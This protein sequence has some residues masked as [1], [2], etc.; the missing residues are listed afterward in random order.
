MTT[1]SSIMYQAA[2]A[3]QNFVIEQNIAKRSFIQFLDVDFNQSDASSAVLQSLTTGLASGTPNKYVE[4]L[5]YG[6]NVSSST[7]PTGVN[8]FST[9]TTASVTLSG[10]NLSINLGANGITSLLAGG[11]GAS[12]PTKTYGDGWY[13]L[14][15]DPTGNP[16]DGQVFWEPF[17]RL[18]GDATG[19]GVV[20]GPY[21][22]AGT[23]AY[24]VYHAE[25]QSG[26]LLNADV[27]GDRAVNSK[28]LTETVTA[29]GDAVGA[30]PTT[31]DYPSFQLLAGVAGPGSAMAVTQSEVQAMVPEAIVAWQAAGL[32]QAGVR[33]LERARIQVGNLG[34]SILGLEA[35]NVITI[36]QTAAGYSWNIGNGGPAPGSVDLLTVLDHELG[37]VIGLADNNQAGD[38]MD[39]TL[40]LGVRRGPTNTDVGLIATASSP[41]PNGPIAKA[42]VDAALASLLGSGGGNGDVAV[43]IT[44]MTSLPAMPAGEFSR[45]AIKPKATGRIIPSALLHPHGSIASRFA[46]RLHRPDQA[47]VT[48]PSRS[49]KKQKH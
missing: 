28:D 8:L 26:P 32:D 27:N 4:L 17:F 13:L 47:T 43:S 40:G 42:T 9:G 7:V 6:E 18:L 5:W 1:F 49:S 44:A 30:G 10:N 20:T 16:S 29:K 46:Y 3:V 19:D 12:S 23:D 35:A 14:G 11:S 38:L 41:V 45:L 33:R 36:N 2:L 22:T 15:I 24:T 39:T 34:S 48:D 37:H 25:G 21:T 31:S